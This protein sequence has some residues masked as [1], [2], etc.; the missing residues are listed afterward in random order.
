MHFK[1]TFF[2]SCHRHF[3]LCTWLLLSLWQ[4]RGPSIRFH[5]LVVRRPMMLLGASCSL[6][7]NV[8][9][10]SLIVIDNA[11]YHSRNDETYPV[12][13]WKKQQ[14]IDWL[15]S[16]DIAVPKN[17]T[18]RTLDYVQTEKDRYLAKI[19]ESIAKNAG[20]ETLH[21]PASLRAQ[22]NQNGLGGP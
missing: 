4:Q 2:T 18:S 17:F 13:K 12:S 16:K 14:Y 19:V 6:C 5:G 11:P 7:T 1:T 15:K 3:V 21:L 9:Q 8:P 22:S 20:H 10:G